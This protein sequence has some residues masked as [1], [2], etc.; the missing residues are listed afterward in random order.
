MLTDQIESRKNH[1]PSQAS[2]GGL[3]TPRFT[4]RRT[5]ARLDIRAAGRLGAESY[6]GQFASVVS[7]TG[8]EQRY[9]RIK[10]QH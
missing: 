9:G 10:S 7:M 5:G 8:R 1:L 4:A 2:W 6:Q 3:R